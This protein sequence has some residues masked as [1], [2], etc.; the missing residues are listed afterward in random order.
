MF[1][2]TWLLFLLG[3][4]AANNMGTKNAAKEWAETYGYDKGRNKRR[5][6]ELYQK[7]LG[8]RI[9]GDKNFRTYLSDYELYCQ[10]QD[11][12]RKEGYVWDPVWDP[13]VPSKND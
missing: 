1:S 9:R 5:Q 2:L 4:K 10:A 7:Y 8:P 3:N 13:Y 6:Q 12:L 11:E